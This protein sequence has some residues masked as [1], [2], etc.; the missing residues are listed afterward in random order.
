[1]SAVEFKNQGNAHLQKGEFDEAIVA[2]TKAIE[3]NPNDHVFFSNRSAAYLSKGDAANALTDADRCIAISSQWPKGYSRKGAALHALRR[4][5]EA[6]DAYQTGLRIAPDDAG[7]KNGLIEVNRAQSAPPPSSFGGAGGNNKSF[8]PPQFLAKLAGHP[9]FGPKLA[10]PNFLN[11]LQMLQTNP[12]I[13]LQDPE[14]MEIL[15]LLME[16]G[17]PAEESESR[18]EPQRASKPAESTSSSSSSSATES[19]LSDEER[20]LKAK[21]DAASAAKERGNQLYKQKKFEEALEAYDEASRNDPAAITYLNNKAAVYIEM[22]EIDRA[23][24]QCNEAIELGRL[25]RASYEEV[26]KVYHRM[27]A[28]HLK[29]DDF[30]SAKECYAKAQTEHFDKAIERKVKNLELEYK[31]KAMQAY[32][33]PELA[34]EAKERGNVAFRANDY[35]TAIREYEDAVKR[36]PTNPAYHNNLAAALQKIGDFNGAK[37]EVEKSLELD[38]NYVKAWAKKGDIEFF[39]KEYHKA[40]DSYRAGLQIEPDNSLC[41]QGLQKTML[42]VNT[43][44]AADDK[45]RAAHAMADPEIQFILQDPMVRQVLQDMQ[46]S[47]QTAQR[48]LADP[49]MR[50]KI[51]KLIASGILQVR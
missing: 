17:G 20:A 18:S 22:G 5:S 29:R 6:I 43:S 1:M 37:R 30:P 50:S 36:D 15:G 34:V 23:L 40:L 39:M 3:L 27:A 49:V 31:K 46:E 21:K 4:Y 12:Q 32:I 8:L 14:I 48:A 9:K 24:E 26:A 28:A 16:Q 25:H 33:N 47:P 11:K 51:D 19:H 38:R 45:E 35:P 13:M 44:N 2:Y 42:Q 10:D 7:L 41:K